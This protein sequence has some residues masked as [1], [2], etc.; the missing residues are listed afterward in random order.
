MVS[1]QLRCNILETTLSIM[2]IAKKHLLRWKRKT[3][4][5]LQNCCTAQSIELVCAEHFMQGC[6]H[7][8]SSNSFTSIFTSS[9]QCFWHLVDIT[10]TIVPSSGTNKDPRLCKE[11]VLWMNLFYKYFLS[12]ARK[13]TISSHNAWLQMEP[14][15]WITYL[16]TQQRIGITLVAGSWYT[17]V[18]PTNGDNP[19]FTTPSGAVFMCSF[20]FVIVQYA[21]IKSVS[22]SILTSKISSLW[23]NSF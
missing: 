10:A 14:P 13:Q 3:N 20:L 6:I 1:Q 5:S 18:A 7:V 16:K 19:Q 12:N 2:M 4:T 21:P 8:I 22:R 9:S 11:F 17:T 15:S 23:F